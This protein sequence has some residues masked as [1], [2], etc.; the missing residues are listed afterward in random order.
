MRPRPSLSVS[1]LV[2]VSTS[3]STT[4]PLI[5]TVPVGLSFTLHTSILALIVDPK[6]WFPS[7]GFAETTPLISP[8]KLGAGLNASLVLVSRLSILGDASDTSP[9]SV[10]VSP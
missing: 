9:T 6:N 3:P 10:H 8:W 5:V 7:H 4:I 2:A 1:P